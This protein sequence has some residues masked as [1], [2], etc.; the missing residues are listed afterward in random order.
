M[1]DLNFKEKRYIEKILE[2]EGGFVLDFRNRTMQEFI[3]DTMGIDIYIDKYN[4]KGE[5]KANRL[6]AFFEIESNYHVGLL[7]EQLLDYWLTQIHTGERNY[8]YTDENL[9]KEC[10]IIVD[11][12]KSGGPV[13]NLDS[14]K[15][16]SKDESFEK[17]AA[18]IKLCIN[19]NEPETGIDRL[20]TFVVKYIRELCVKYEIKF[21]KETPLHSLF[22]MYIKHLGKS[23]MLESE[24]TTRILKSSISILEAF[25]NVRNDQSFAHDNSILNYNES[26]LIFNN[27]SNVIRFIETIEKKNEPKPVIENPFDSGI[28]L[29]F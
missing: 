13:E 10:L 16:N 15:P 9:H 8:D 1:S 6:R 23:N 3:I 27:I 29:P 28:D 4:I 20:H 21:E 22:G 5:S 17:L 11:R 18:T 25:N 12:L 19:N 2:M 7:L 26:L 14:I 24:M